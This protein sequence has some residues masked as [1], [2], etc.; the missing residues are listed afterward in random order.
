MH[1]VLART[2]FERDVADL[3]AVAANSYQ[4]TVN[5]RV[6]PIL[7]VTI[8]HSRP[9]RLRLRADDWDD[10]PPS[11]EL[12]NPDGS[13]MTDRL[14]GSI[15]HPGPHPATGRPFI[16]MRGSREF[17]THPSHLNESWAQ[18]RGQDGMGLIGI[19]MQIATTWR[20]QVR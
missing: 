13:A 15:F 2:N 6:Y 14:P 16:C 8:C 5:G 12:L 18:Y 4:L 9:L 10:Q 20:E 3:G 17:H 1:E 11:I 7:D 19:V